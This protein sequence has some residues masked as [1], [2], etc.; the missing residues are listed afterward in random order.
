MKKTV[1]LCTLLAISLSAKEISL[2]SRE[3]KISLKSIPPNIRSSILPN[4]SILMMKSGDLNRDKIDDMVVILKDNA[5]DN[6]TREEETPRPLYLFLGQKKGG[7]TLVAKN[8]RVVLGKDSGGVFGDPLNGVSIKNGYFSIEHY[9]GSNWRWTQISTFVYNP[10]YKDWTLH[11]LGNTSYHTSEPELIEEHIQD[12]D[13][14]GIV[15]FE[16]FKN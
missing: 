11:K 13:D 15:K 12:V 3:A 10:K 16:E 9:G 1:I 4:H 14:F 6:E 8:N 5:E 7:Y 2:D